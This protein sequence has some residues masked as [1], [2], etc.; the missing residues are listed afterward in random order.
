MVWQST[1]HA[2]L[3]VL[4]EFPNSPRYD[5]RLE[6]LQVDRRDVAE[7]DMLLC[8]VDRVGIIAPV[9]VTHL[10]VVD[11]HLLPS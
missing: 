9:T 7:S 1:R 3:D 4:H 11:V 8:V 2:E 6:T 5:I 10:F